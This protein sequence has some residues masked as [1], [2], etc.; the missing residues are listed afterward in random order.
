MQSTHCLLKSV[1][2]AEFDK[3]HLRLGSYAVEFQQIVEDLSRREPTQNDWRHL[4][5]LFARIKRFVDVHFR[6]EK[7][8]MLK[9][10]YPDYP[11]HKKMHDNFTQEMQKIQSHINN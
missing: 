2:I 4:D 1:G 3:Q 10:N 7:G 8:M 9:Y 6:K 5:G 11:S